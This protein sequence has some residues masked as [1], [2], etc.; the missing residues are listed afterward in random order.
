MTHEVNLYK[1]NHKILAENIVKD[2]FM[3][4][5]SSKRI[6]LIAYEEKQ[7]KIFFIEIKRRISSSSML[8]GLFEL[9]MIDENKIPKQYEPHLILLSGYADNPKK[10]PRKFDVLKDIFFDDTMKDQCKFVLLDPK[11]FINGN[12][13]YNL[14]KL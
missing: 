2:K 9:S 11:Q 7:K 4:F 14:L 12:E 1:T 8:S 13:F 3:D 10:Y 5:K 6:D